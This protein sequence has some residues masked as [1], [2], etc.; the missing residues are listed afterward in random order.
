MDEAWRIRQGRSFDSVAD[1]YDR[2]RPTFPTAAVTWMLEPLHHL[3][4]P[5]LP[6]HR[7]LDLAAGTG[8]L[9][10]PLLAAG[11]V[12]LAT[13]PS[14]PML[15]RLRRRSPGARV[16]A[17]AGTAEQLPLRA[18]AVDAV[19]IATAYHWFD[20]D[21]AVPE[22]GRVLRPGGVLAMAWNIRDESVPWVRRL[23]ELIGSELALPDPTGTLG[24]SGLF[25]PIEW[26]RFRFYQWLDR[27]R[28]LDLVRSRSYVAVLAE[29]DRAALLAG[30]G[31]LYDERR[32][33]AHGMQMPYDTH[34]LRTVRLDR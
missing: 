33:D 30:V 22:L 18:D 14:L 34:C 31:E 26:Q 27:E 17:V 9:T 23:T 8:A 12:V 13:D 15:T 25:G 6:R 10:R 32:G 1:E 4:G 3:P 20:T 24:L 16:A 2:G 5:G 7:V 11:H 21:L 28:L 29:D 19:T